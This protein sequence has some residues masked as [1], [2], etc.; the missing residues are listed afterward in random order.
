MDWSL[1]FTEKEKQSFSLLNFDDMWKKFYGQIML[2]NIQ[3]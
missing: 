1:D 2:L 3:I